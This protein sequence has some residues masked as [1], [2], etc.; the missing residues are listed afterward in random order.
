MNLRFLYK[1]RLI[2]ILTIIAVFLGITKLRYKNVDWEK[3]EPIP[4]VVV[5][6]T[7]APQ[8]NTK[9]PLW[10]SIPFSGDGFKIDHYAEPLVLVIKIE[11]GE[12]KKVVEEEVF[13]WMR[14]NKVATESHK[15]IF[16]E[17]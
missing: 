8:I 6:P 9:Y 3:T 4:T 12:E 10:E 13:N 16:E 15:L 1:Y 5:S 17:E 7:S 11:E 14:E 2:I